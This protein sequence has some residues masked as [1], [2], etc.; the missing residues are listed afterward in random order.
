MND[1]SEQQAKNKSV[2]LPTLCAILIAFVLLPLIQTLSNQL[3]KPLSAAIIGVPDGLKF[4]LSQSSALSD[5]GEEVMTEN[6]I[7]ITPIITEFIASATMITLIYIG[8][9]VLRNRLPS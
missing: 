6:A 7:A 9:R 8:Y 5:S 4:I 1:V 3:I 2:F